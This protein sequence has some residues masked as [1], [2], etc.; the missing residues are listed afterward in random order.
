VN[1]VGKRNAEPHN[2]IEIGGMGIRNL[3]ALIKTDSEN[4]IFVSPVCSKG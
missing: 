4:R 3:H 1:H 2:E